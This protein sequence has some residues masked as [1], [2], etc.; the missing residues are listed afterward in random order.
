VKTLRE[1]HSI[2]KFVEFED[3]KLWLTRKSCGF[4]CL[5]F[6]WT[7]NF[8]TTSVFWAFQANKIYCKNAYTIVCHHS[9]LVSFISKNHSVY[10]N[11]SDLIRPKKSVQVRYQTQL[12]YMVPKSIKFK[13]DQFNF[14]RWCILFVQFLPGPQNKKRMDKTD[15]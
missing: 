10:L 8:V 12:S 2:G 7:D 11:A 9:L 14:W 4:G 3:L 15:P 13:K 5:M 1:W 6:W